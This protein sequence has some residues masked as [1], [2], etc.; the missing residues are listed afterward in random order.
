MKAFNRLAYVL[1]VLYGLVTGLAILLVG[2]G[3]PFLGVPGLDDFLKQNSLTIAAVGAGIVSFIVL[4]LLL[5]LFLRGRE[6]SIGFSGSRGDVRIAHA[7]IEDFVRRL[8]EAMPG[9]RDCRCKMEQRRDGLIALVRLALDAGV[10]VPEMAESIQHDVASH[11]QEV[12][13]LEEISEVRLTVDKLVY[14]GR[15]RRSEEEEF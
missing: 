12:M 8:C 4:I 15:E 1:L 13:G 11:L 2:T 9:V 14:R 10:N 6:P 3:Y 7:A 5:N